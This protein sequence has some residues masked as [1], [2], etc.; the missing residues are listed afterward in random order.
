MAHRAHT[1]SIR[2]FKMVNCEYKTNI[3]FFPEDN[4]KKGFL[5]GS[6]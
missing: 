6:E 2:A 4:G 5:E 1:D 3:A